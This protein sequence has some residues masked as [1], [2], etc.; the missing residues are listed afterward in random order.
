[1]ETLSQAPQVPFHTAVHGGLH[2]L[3]QISLFQQEKHMEKMFIFSFYP[4]SKGCSGFCLALEIF[5]V[6][7]E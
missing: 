1:M 4:V 7:T 6:E 2:R 3:L 5:C